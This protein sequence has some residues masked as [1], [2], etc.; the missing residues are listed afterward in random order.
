M[1]LVLTHEFYFEFKII[2]SQFFPQYFAMGPYFQ[3]THSS[4]KDTLM[5]KNLNLFSMISIAQGS[6][7][8]T[9]SFFLFFFT[10]GLTQNNVT[11]AIF[12]QKNS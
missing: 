11:G 3:P 12:Q 8:T 9:V 10:A 5:T 6:P 1:M 4:A 2:K 7:L